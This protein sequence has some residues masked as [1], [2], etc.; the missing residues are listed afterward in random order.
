[1]TSPS[2]TRIRRALRSRYTQES[3]I[4]GEGGILWRSDGFPLMQS[5]LAEGSAGDAHVSHFSISEKAADP[6]T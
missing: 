5:V 1:M 6:S 2:S 4:R 3:V